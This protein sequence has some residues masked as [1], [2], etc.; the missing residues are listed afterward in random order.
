MPYTPDAPCWSPAVMFHGGGDGRTYS[1][2][3]AGGQAA[4]KT[5]FICG[6]G[7][8]AWR[9]RHQTG[10]HGEIDAKRATSSGGLADRL[11]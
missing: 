6:F 4:R 3:W 9:E 7:L 1:G 11:A 8:L 10:T 5:L 2:V